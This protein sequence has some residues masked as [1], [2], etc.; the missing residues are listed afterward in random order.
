MY[1]VLPVEAMPGAI[2]MM[3]YLLSV[4]ALMLGFIVMRHA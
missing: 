3:C 1:P 2:Q 4:M